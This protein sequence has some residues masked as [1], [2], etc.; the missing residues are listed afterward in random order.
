M[1]AFV[2]TLMTTAGVALDRGRADSPS[3]LSSLAGAARP[4]RFGVQLPYGIAALEP[5]LSAR[6]IARHCGAH[7]DYYTQE[8]ARLVRGTAYAE[9]S[10]ED[11]LRAGALQRD[12]VLL[13][14]AAHLHN[15]QLYWNSMTPGGGGCPDGALMQ[16]IVDSFGSWQEFCR[17]FRARA[18]NRLW[19]GWQWLVR[20]GARLVLVNSM[21]CTSPLLKGQTPLLALDLWEYAYYAD[22]GD[23]RAAY[24]EAFLHHLV[25]WRAVA[26]R[27][28]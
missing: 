10:L 26:A 1:S 7:A 28:V 17:I 24:V 12:A 18:A 25:D 3:S 19:A 5:H 8:V 2:D 27:F 22:Y 11:I 23:N 21:Q 15:H 13:G 20:D 14:A 16:A 6:A 4:S 9:R